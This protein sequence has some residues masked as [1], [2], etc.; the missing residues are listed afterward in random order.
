[1]VDAGLLL[2]SAATVAALTGEVAVANL[3][4]SEEDQSRLV[5]AVSFT[6]A[7][8][9]HVAIIG[10]SGSGKSELAMLL[11]R[12][13]RPTGGLITVGGIDIAELPVAVIGRRI[14]YANSI[15]HMFSGTLRDNLL[16]G[17]RHQPVKPAEYDDGSARRRARQLREARNSGNIDLDL[18]ADWIDYE[19]AGVAGP[20]ELTPRIV[21]VL[22]LLDFQQDV[23]SFGLRGQI[24]PTAQPQVAERLLEA[25]RA[26]SAK[27]TTSSATTRTLRLP[28][29]C[30]SAP[31]SDPLSISARWPKI[32]MCCAF[33]TRLR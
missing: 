10:Q 22:A 30:C 21:E 3:S 1:M 20:A 26:L 25:R 28:K 11:A 7:A 13:V 23:Y 6:I 19:S 14:G 29:T 8:G 9:E 4:L 5:D 33:W 17:L 32:V 27:P 12:L 16:L 15:P 2:D 18:H 31:R 24:D